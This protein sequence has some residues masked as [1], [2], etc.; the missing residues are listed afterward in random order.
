MKR[1]TGVVAF[2]GTF[3][4]DECIYIVQ[5]N[6]GRGDLFKEMIRQGGVMKEMHVCTE[7]SLCF[8]PLFRLL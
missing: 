3:E 7:V 6:C 8:W 5:E 4:D 1:F 2:F